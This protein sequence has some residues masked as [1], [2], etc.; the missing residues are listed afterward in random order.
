[1]SEP[2]ERL[3][4]L[5]FLGY[6]HLREFSAPVIAEYRDRADIELLDGTVADAVALAQERVRLGGVDAFISA[7][8][9]GGLLRHA[10]RAPVATIQLGGLDILQALIDARRRSRRVGVILYGQTLAELDAI[11]GLLKI[12]VAQRAYRTPGDALRAF[13]ELRE[14]GCDTIVGTSIVVEMAEAAG[15]DGLLA[16]SLASVR[17]GF[18]EAIELARVA[19]MEAERYAQL[20]GVLHTLEHAVLAVDRSNQVI[21]ANPPMQRI[22]SAHGGP[23]LGR[24]LA[25]LHPA[26]SL[27]DTL[28][29][30]TSDRA[31]VLTI[32]ERHWIANRT[33]IRVQ[34]EITGAALTLYDA[35]AI[36]EADNSLRI[37]Q[38]RQQASA[39]H[40]FDE[41]EG[42]APPFL[43][44]VQTARRFARTDLTVLIS[45]QSG[46]GKELFAQAIHNESPRA[47]KPF[48]A[49]NCAAFSESLLESELFG[50]E[51]GAFTGARRGGKR[52]LF[53]SAHSGTVFLDEIGDMPLALQTRLL[54]VLQEREVLRVGGT[55]PIPVDLRVIAA[56]HQP[57]AEMVAQ[58]RFRQDLYF[59]INTLRLSLPA[60]RE[61]PGDVLPMAER[62]VRLCLA[63]LRAPARPAGPLLDAIRPRLQAYDWPG[64]VRELENVCERLAVFLLQFDAKQ[65]ID[66]TTLPPECPELFDRPAEPRSVSAEDPAERMQDVLARHFGN[67]QATAQ[68]L[69]I[70]RSTLWR[71]L[72][73][74]SAA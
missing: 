59:R 13:T 38:R 57:L 62:R 22:L 34:G 9:N 55:V 67:H 27:Q 11:Q 2:S 33:P 30:G 50:Y 39:R 56:S 36:H 65:A 37:Q 47:D 15:L 40:R 4:R 52:G 70:S 17:Q 60:L 7:G 44:A 14:A 26:L 71:R 18:D 72:K 43:Q 49:V 54:R 73:Q 61:R 16:Y 63:R 3:P 5:C 64:N 53:E 6:R 20:N 19:R 46:T 24:D 21:A 69:G 10:V 8:A 51:D 28:D 42:R 31:R 66:W 68:A 41:L 12:E 74:E 25:T 58:G 35:R 29:S 48:I 1:M 32:A 23:V 45:G